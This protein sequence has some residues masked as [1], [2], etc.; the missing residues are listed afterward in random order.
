[1]ASFNDT[2]QQIVN[3]STEEKVGLAA[4]SYLKILP[5]LKEVDSKTNGMT[6]LCAILGSAAG[7][8]GKLNSAETALIQAI[9]KAEGLELDSGDV[10]QLVQSSTRDDVVNVVRKLA[11][12]MSSEQQAALVA[13]AAAMCSIDDKIS[14]DEV[15]YIA[16]LLKA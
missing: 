13:L 2:L 14:R 12:I 10:K 1:M 15:A 7:A 9:L 3:L 16:G 6:L 8:D 4:T 11:G 5:L